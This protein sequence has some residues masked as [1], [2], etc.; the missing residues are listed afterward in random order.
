MA[1][2]LSSGEVKRILG[3]SYQTLTNWRLKGILIPDFSLPTGRYRYSRT[4][5]EEFQ[6]R[7]ASNG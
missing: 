2:T 3:V 1:D 4:Q 7:F 5:I 6:K